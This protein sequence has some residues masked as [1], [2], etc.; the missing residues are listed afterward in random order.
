MLSLLYADDF[1]L[2][3]ESEEDVKAIVG[4]CIVLCRRRGLKLNRAESKVVGEEEESVCEVL[5]DGTRL[6]HIP[7][8]K[9]LG[10]SFG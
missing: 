10:L 8:F 7:E 4:R 1:Y 6:V 5:V 3:G 2:C 9:Y